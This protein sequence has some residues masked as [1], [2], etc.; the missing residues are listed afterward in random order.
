MPPSRVWKWRMQPTRSLGSLFSMRLSAIPGYYSGL[1]APG[2]EQAP[3]GLRQ[4]R[5]QGHGAT[6]KRAPATADK[7]SPRTRAS[8]SGNMPRRGSATASGVSSR[9]HANTVPA[10]WRPPQRRLARRMT[11]CFRPLHRGS[12][13]A[14]AATGGWQAGTTGRVVGAA[15]QGLWP[16]A[17]AR[18][19]AQ[20]GAG[21]RACRTRDV[22]NQK[23][24]QRGRAL[25]DLQAQRPTME[26]KAGV[27]QEQRSHK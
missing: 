10:W 25:P 24:P 9:P 18:W 11:C 14:D 23:R 12:N 21:L 15:A 13:A 27:L 7:G 3:P 22:E 1:V 8:S 2:T 17:R 6:D 5:A 19:P 4:R 26:Q 20:F 16:C